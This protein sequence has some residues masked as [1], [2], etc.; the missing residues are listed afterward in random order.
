MA[1]EMQTD[2]RDTLVDIC[3]AATTYIVE[4]TQNTNKHFIT[5]IPHKA[6]KY[7]HPLPIISL[8]PRLPPL[9][10][11]L[12]PPRNLPHPIFHPVRHV[13]Q[14]IAGCFRSSRVIHRV[15][16]STT[17]CTYYVAEG[18]GDA[19]DGFADLFRMGG[20]LD[21]VVGLRG[22]GEGIRRGRTVPVTVVTAPVMPFL[23]LLL[24]VSR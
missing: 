18:V 22:E 23:L 10:P 16:Y 21:G 2:G 11:P 4:G 19:A 15:A 17:C 6:R 9:T 14:R 20:V 7:P 1:L 5:I 13:L 8:L 24:M 3:I 12:N